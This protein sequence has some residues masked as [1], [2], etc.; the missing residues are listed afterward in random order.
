[1]SRDDRGRSSTRRPPLPDRE[2][3]AW[4][5]REEGSTN[6]TESLVRSAVIFYGVLALA[7]IGLAVILPGNSPGEGSESAL[8]V[9]AGRLLR[10]LDFA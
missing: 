9:L 4:A 2:P 3:L 5:R 8:G 1:M 6:L 10:W 7:G